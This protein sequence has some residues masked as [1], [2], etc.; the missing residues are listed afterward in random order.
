MSSTGYSIPKFSAEMIAVGYK[1]KEIWGQPTEKSWDKDAPYWHLKGNGGILSTAE[2][3]YKWNQALASDTILSSDAKKK[4]YHPELRPNEDP[5]PYYGYGWDMFKTKRNTFVARHNG[6]NRI[7]FADFHRYLD[8]RVTIISL[9]NRANQDFVPINREISR[10]IFEPGYQPTIPAENNEANRVFTSEII[11]IASEK[12]FEAAW[13]AYRGRKKNVDLLE[14]MVNDKGYELISEKKL[15]K[16]IDVFRVNTFAFPRS[17][18][19]YDSLGEAYLESGNN[20]LAI[21]NYKKSL[22]FDPENRHAENVIKRL[23]GK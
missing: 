9:S 17:G 2:D 7:F 18:N 1:D 5:N 11:A 19:A 23:S 4:Y 20:E 10:L 15:G 3:L 6:T 22:Q 21:A 16:S 14:Q 12:G 8:E 13:T